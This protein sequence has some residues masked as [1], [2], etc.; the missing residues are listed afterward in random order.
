MYHVGRNGQQTG[1]F[2]IEQ[3]KTMA[4]NGELQPTD[5]VWKE[6]MAGWEPASTLP[7]VFGAAPSPSAATAIEMPQAANPVPLAQATVLPPAP[8]PGGPKPNPLALTGMILGIVSILLVCCCYGFPFNVAGIVCSIIGMNQIKAS[9]GTQPGMGMAQAG[10]WCSVASIVLGILFALF[11]FAVNWQ[12]W[13]QG[14]K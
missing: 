12:Q 1:P 5:L 11:G 6:G 13:T 7:G 4:A 3:L 8:G 10:L 9:G 2:S 14:M